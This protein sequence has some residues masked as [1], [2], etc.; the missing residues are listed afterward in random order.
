MSEHQQFLQ[1]LRA[2]GVRLTPQRVMILNILFESDGHLTAEHIF[3][4]ARVSYPYLDLST[5]YRTLEFLC[6][7]HITT[8]TDLGGGQKVYEL[9][10]EQPHHHLVCRVCGQMIEADHALFEPLQRALMER[11]GFAADILHF[12]VFGVCESCRQS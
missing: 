6:D 8:E 2:N 11:Y 7:R 5:V 12:A 9:V 10:G 1:T 4:R 3:E